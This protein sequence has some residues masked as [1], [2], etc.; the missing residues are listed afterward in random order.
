[1]PDDVIA[2]SEPFFEHIV[3]DRSN[4]ETDRNLSDGDTIRAGGRRLRAVFRPGH[5]TTDSL[6]V[7][8]ATGD[9]FVGDRPLASITSGAELMPT[10]LPRGGRCSSTWGTCAR[11]KRLQLRTCSPAHRPTVDDHRQLIEERMAFHSSRL[12]LIAHHVTAG[13]STAFEIAREL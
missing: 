3:R 11:P 5:S 2:A 6:F 12:D 7:D 13:C 8:D 9:A 1:V 10:D 4:F